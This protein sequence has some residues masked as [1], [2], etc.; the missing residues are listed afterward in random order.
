GPDV[1][2]LLLAEDAVGGERLPQSLP[3]ERLGGAIGLGDRGAIALVLDDEAVGPEPPQ[4][5]LGRFRG[6]GHRGIEHRAIDG[7]AHASSYVT[8]SPSARNRT[9]RPTS[10]VRLTAAGSAGSAARAPRRLPSGRRTMTGASTGPRS[11]SC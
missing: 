2:V 9:V 11:R 5:Q 1:L 3:H 10:W 8:R 7:W 6:D 4:R